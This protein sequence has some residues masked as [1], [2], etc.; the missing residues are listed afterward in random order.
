MVGPK[1]DLKR[2]ERELSECIDGEEVHGDAELA[3]KILAAKGVS[4]QVQ[5]YFIRELASSTLQKI[6][7]MQK[8]GDLEGAENLR[9]DTINADISV[10]LDEVERDHPELVGLI[11]EIRRSVTEMKKPIP[12]N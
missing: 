4:V 3:F 5:I 9:V 6:R 1:I 7:E 2:L 12:F 8:A 11:I 10:D